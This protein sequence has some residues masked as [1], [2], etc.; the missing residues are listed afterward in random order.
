[1]GFTAIEKKL[2]AQGVKFTKSAIS[3]LLRNEKYQ[4]DML[5]QKT[6]TLDHI[7]KKQIINKGQMPQF[8]IQG[9]H[10]SIVSR[11]LFAEVQAEIARRAEYFNAKPQ[12]PKSYPFTGMIRCGKCGA[13]YRRKHTAAGTKYD[14]V[15]WIC[16]TFNTY[17]KSEC[18]SQQI[19][20][21]ILEAKVTEAGGLDNI[22]EIIVPDKNR[23]TFI[24]N[25]SSSRDAGWEN[26]SRRQS[27]TPQMREIARQRQFDRSKT[28]GV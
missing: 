27:W 24:L 16:G 21:A 26:P 28:E 14:K 19:P 5:L 8:F 22:T 9:S 12:T 4:G 15:V 13:N 1:M 2:R 11:E 25:D 23:L 18:D 17:G 10:E 20:E 3:K 7:S 6:F